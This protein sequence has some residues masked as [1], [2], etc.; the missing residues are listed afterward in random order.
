MARAHRR[1]Q[2]AI[3][4]D[5]VTLLAEHYSELVGVP[6]D[7]IIC[8]V[9]V[10]GEPVPKA[11]ARVVRGGAYTPER[12]VNQE[13]RIQQYLKVAYPQI[14]PYAGPVGLLVQV[15]FKGAGR[16]DWDNFG[17]LVSDALNKRA[18]LDDKQVVRATVELFPCDPDPST[19]VVVYRV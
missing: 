3:R 13:Q 2:A 10:P 15:R 16:G 4:T 9:R 19:V 14:T 5:A 1:V 17:K 6:E 8:M 18:Y 11:R 12:T 7:R